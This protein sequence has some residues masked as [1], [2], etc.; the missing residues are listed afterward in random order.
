MFNKSFIALGVLVFCLKIMTGNAADTEDATILVSNGALQEIR[1]KY[2]PQF[3]KSG[4]RP[5]KLLAYTNQGKDALV[6]V[7][8][9]NGI[10]CTLKL[11]FDRKPNARATSTSYVCKTE[12]E[13][14]VHANAHSYA[15][16]G[17]DDMAKKIREEIEKQRRKMSNAFA[18][19]QVL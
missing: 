10:I 7:G 18:M 6:V 8:E 5:E 3:R 13:G 16:N 9:D 15:S 11:A 14:S 19:N 12:G 17:N 4:I 2:G 1:Q